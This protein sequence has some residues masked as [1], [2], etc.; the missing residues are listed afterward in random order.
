MAELVSTRGQASC[1]HIWLVQVDVAVGVQDGN[2]VAQSSFVELRV[3][4]TPDNVVLI[5]PAGLW[6]VEATGVILT[7]TDLQDPE[8]IAC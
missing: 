8:G 4:E 2:V 1:V 7:N 5:M 3:L 6:W